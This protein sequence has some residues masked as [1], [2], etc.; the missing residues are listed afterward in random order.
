MVSLDSSFLIDLL[1][2]EP[3]AVSKAVELD[4]TLEP[5]YLTV[6]AA[7]EVMIGAYRLGGVYFERTK[8]LVDRL[9]LLAFDRACYHQ[10][11]RLGAELMKRGTPLGL[12]DLFVAAISMRYGERLLTNDCAFRSVPG[13]TI[14]TY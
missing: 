14:E 12:G 3:R 11:G 2:G 9:P 7:S 6:P 1:A 10:T 4:R 5:R 13:L 8:T